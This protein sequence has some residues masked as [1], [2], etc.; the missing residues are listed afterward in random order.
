MITYQ[1]NANPYII[2]YQPKDYAGNT[3][4]GEV[5]L[6]CSL[7]VSPKPLRDCVFRRLH[8]F[9]QP[10]LSSRGNY[11]DIKYYPH[12]DTLKKSLAAWYHKNGVGVG[13]LTADHF[14]LGNGSYDILCNL[15]L[16]CLT[17]SKRV[18]GHAPQFTAYVDHV[19]CSGSVYESY[20]LDSSKQY[21]FCASDYLARM[22]SDYDL[23][24]V[25]N[26]NNPTGQEIP[27]SDLRRLAQR[28]RELNRI[29]IVDEAYGEYI[30]FSESA[31]QLVNEFPQVIVTRTFSKG[32]GMAGIRLGYAAA[33]PDSNLLPQLQKLLL[34]FNC[35]GLARE[36]ANAVL[37]DVLERSE[38]PFDLAQIQEDKQILLGALSG[39]Q[40][41]YGTGLCAAKT[42]PSA[43]ITMLYYK[44][45]PD[46]FHLQRH[47][48]KHGL[49]TVS[50][51]TYVGLD[52]RSVR[53]ML[54][55]H[56]SIP[57]LLQL[58]EEAVRS[59]P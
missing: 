54:P 10:Q 5:V 11:E 57:L 44:N 34:P 6:D 29:L 17:N 4:P 12:S 55:D 13:W 22:C 9:C 41:H 36:L 37:L 46:G 48:M 3:P 8:A 26:P 24:I 1:I 19:N 51:E 18:L 14:I 56:A 45:G 31:I 50:C 20:Y 15:N 40:E 32:W 38:D 42:S 35:N 7:G 33:S 43:P 23:F 16:L 27:L 52:S 28:A 2:G 39:W 49:L 47:L 25:E 21:A 58:L 59:L 30:P 53:L